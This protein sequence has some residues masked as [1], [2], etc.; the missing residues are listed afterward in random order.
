MRR[1]FGYTFFRSLFFDAHLE[2]EFIHFHRNYILGLRLKEG[3]R[4][5]ASFTLLELDLIHLLVLYTTQHVY[6]NKKGKI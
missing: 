5:R 1:A 2:S 3:S 4:A 6:I